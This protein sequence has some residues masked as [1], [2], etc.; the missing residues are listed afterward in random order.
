ML[1]R[2]RVVVTGLG[3][4]APNGIGKTAFWNS[5]LTRKS[6]IGRITLFDAS[7][8]KS[9]IA[10]EVKNFDL[11]NYYEPKTKVD[12][13]ARHTQ[14]ALAAATLA[15]A[16][17]G[18]QGFKGDRDGGA[19][20]VILGVSSSAMDVIAHGTDR[21]QTRGPARVPSYSIDASIPQQAASV[22]ARELGFAAR[23]QTVSSACAAGLEAIGE[24]CAAIWQGRTDL[25]VAGGGDAHITPLP[26]ACLDRAGLASRRNDD[27]ERASRPFDRDSDSGVI[28]EGVAVVILENLQHALARGARLYCE[29]TGYGNHGDPDPAVPCS[30]LPGA[31]RMA[32]ANA[33][34]RPE[35]ID[36][37]C[38]HGPGH[39]VIDRVETQMIKEALGAHAYRVPVTSIK[40][41]VGNPV[42]A[43][44]PMQLVACAC[45]LEQ[46]AIPPIANLEH[47]APGCDLDYVM[48]DPRVARVGCILLNVHGLGGGNGSLIV[49]RVRA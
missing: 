8:F 16:D 45:I 20:P 39:P 48:H 23:A 15:L 19:V 32:L 47:P 34:R 25:A 14:F 42:A 46:N 49:E 1:S 2:Q 12:R 43:A 9:Q 6:G 13:L 11:L 10:G 5:L 4:V 31:I 7:E 33:G 28:S 38:A 27:P 41:V 44:G 18:L 40:G 3:I 17:A 21:L 26:F 36:C 30:G 37:I 35:D 24:A 29:L 22:L